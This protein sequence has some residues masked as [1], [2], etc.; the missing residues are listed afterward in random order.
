MSKTFSVCF[1]ILVWSAVFL[2]AVLLPRPAS[3][4]QSLAGGADLFAPSYQAGEEMDAQRALPVT[5]FYASDD[6]KAA[7]PGTLVRF[8]PATDFALPPGITATRILYHTRSTSNTDALAS[9]VVLVPYGS[10]RLEVG[11]S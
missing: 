9:G 5:A 2:T 1:H 7:E 3:A 6:L 10:P 11:L 8:E 4:Q